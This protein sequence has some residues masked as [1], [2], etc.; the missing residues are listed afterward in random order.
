MSRQ[1]LFFMEIVE[2]RGNAEGMR[3]AVEGIFGIGVV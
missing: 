3:V 1:D 2:V